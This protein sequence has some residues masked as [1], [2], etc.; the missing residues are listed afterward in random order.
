[1]P[2]QALGLIETVGMVSAL[3]AADAAAKAAEVRVVDRILSKGSGMIT[4]V[5]EG[6]VAAVQAAVEAGVAE[7][8][9]LGKVLASQVIPRPAAGV[10]DA[11]GGGFAS[12]TAP[13]PAV[14][15][16]PAPVVPAPAPPATAGETDDSAPRRRG[17]R[18]SAT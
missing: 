10:R 8:N 16:P 17:G 6:D 5:L 9:R 18:G 15:V 7:G 4:I 2:Q 1:M 11:M 3:A 14:P 12:A 13:A